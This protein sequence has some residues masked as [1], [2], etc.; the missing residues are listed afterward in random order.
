MSRKRDVVAELCF[1]G[2]AICVVVGCTIQSQPVVTPSQ[3]TPT[4]SFSSALDAPQQQWPPTP[5][6]S[7]SATMTKKVLPIPHMAK[8][9]WVQY[10]GAGVNTKLESYTS[11]DGV[12]DPPNKLVDR[13]RLFALEPYSDQAGTGGSTALYIIA[14]AYADGS[15]VM[16]R[17]M[18]RAKPGQVLVITTEAGKVCY[19]VDHIAK[20]KKQD[21]EDGTAN[22]TK[23]QP[24]WLRFITCYAAPGDPS[25]VWGG[26]SSVLYAQMQPC[27]A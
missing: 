17:I 7:P 15:G 27:A 9:V 26:Y 16:N 5:P 20:E 1:I 25:T 19:R 24:G 14:H 23:R 13:E 2:A 22:A 18:A 8:A 21:I 3:S 11:P 4:T 10:P 6:P 12:L